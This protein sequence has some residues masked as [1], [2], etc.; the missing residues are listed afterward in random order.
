MFKGTTLVQESV[1]LNTISD[2][3]SRIYTEPDSLTFS[4]WQYI[5]LFC[6]L[7]LFDSFVII[8]GC[9]GDKGHV[10]CFLMGAWCCICCLCSFISLE[11]YL[12]PTGTTLIQEMVYLITTGDWK[13]ASEVQ[14]DE[15]FPFIDVLDERY[16]FY[17]GIKMVEKLPR[18]RLIKSHLH[19]FLLPEQLKHGKGKVKL[20]YYF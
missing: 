18:P 4:R 19:H 15:R 20:K 9:C 5:C 1:Y 8:F 14:L 11:L 3:N 13:R 7:C 6:F 10:Y 17:G 12:I 16:P 2:R